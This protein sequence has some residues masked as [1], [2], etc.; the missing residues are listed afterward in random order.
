MSAANDEEGQ[1]TS[2][3]YLL[4]PALPPEN[5]IFDGGAG[6]CLAFYHRSLRYREPPAHTATAADVEVLEEWLL[7]TNEIG[8][9]TEL[10]ALLSATPLLNSSEL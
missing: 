3:Y 6:N 1:I 10:T 8:T 7:T 2:K 5:S 9:D 4:R